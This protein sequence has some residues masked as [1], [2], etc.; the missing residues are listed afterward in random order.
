MAS[1]AAY[2]HR[3]NQRQAE[4]K[5]KQGSAALGAPPQSQIG[6]QSAR[7]I[8]GGPGSSHRRPP[9]S[10]AGAAGAAGSRFRDPWQKGSNSIIG[11]SSVDRNI[12]ELGVDDKDPVLFRPERGDL[13]GQSALQLINER[14][15]DV[16]YRLHPVIGRTVEVGGQVDIAR[17]LALLS[18]KCA[19]NKV[20]LDFNKQRF[21]ERA[22]M[23]RKRLRRERWRVRFKEGFKATCSRVRDLAKQGW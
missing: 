19:T 21:H 8:L 20:K 18:M 14:P 3:L 5:Q 10:W 1:M 7:S 12:D 2:A 16:K 6:L 17:G 13:D 9:P 22:G 23:K 4:A 11:E 15:V